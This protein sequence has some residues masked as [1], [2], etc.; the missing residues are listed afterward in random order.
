MQRS[1]FRVRLLAAGSAIAIA[2]VV[3]AAALVVFPHSGAQSSSPAAA[4]PQAMP[5][6]VAVVEQ[7]DVAAWDEFS[8]RLEAVEKRHFAE[9]EPEICTETG[10]RAAPLQ[11]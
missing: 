9:Q 7:R 2:A 1:S 8:G 11:G 5:V 4:A 6:S 10:H 3:G